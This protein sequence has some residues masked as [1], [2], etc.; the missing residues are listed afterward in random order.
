M[1]RKTATPPKLI[2]SVGRDVVQLR[3]DRRRRAE[4]AR[5]A[6]G[7]R[8]WPRAAG[9]SRT[10]RRSTSRRSRAERDA[11]ADLL[12]PL[13]HR[14]RQHAVDADRREQQATP[15][16][17]ANMMPKSRC[18]QKLRSRGAPP[19]SGR[20]TP[21]ATDRRRGS[22]SRAAPAIDGGL[23]RDTNRDPRVERRARTD[24]AHTRRAPADHLPVAV[25]PEVGDDADDGEPVGVWS[26]ARR[27]AAPSGS[28]SGQSRLAIAWLMRA[29]GAL[30]APSVSVKSRPAH[31]RHVIDL[32]QV[33][34]GATKPTNG[35]SPRSTA[36]P[37][38]A[39]AR[40]PRRRRSARSSRQTQTPRRAATPRGGRCPRRAA[41][42][43]PAGCTA[44]P[45]MK[46]RIVISGPVSKP[47]A[48]ACRFRKLRTK[49]DAPTSSTSDSAISTTTSVLRSRARR[50]LVAVPRPPSFNSPGG[51][52][53]AWTAGA[54]PKTIPV[55]GE[56]RRCRPAR[57]RRCSQCT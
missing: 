34:R 16:K 45:G 13:R 43:R 46:N 9:R 57:A 32:T 31:Q 19:S 26:P 51:S 38:R 1:V 24:T 55:S 37:P 25:V 39:R 35:S 23:T 53:A 42:L 10:T 44:S 49:S 36:V 52:R 56:M 18:C 12:R 28:S 21:A 5:P 4:R 8:R 47:S 41:P 17:T 48:G 27:N 2:G 40:L 29:T 33:R 50:P 15:P 20:R 30:V 11:H 22:A 7:P 14:E 6:R 54:S 3:A